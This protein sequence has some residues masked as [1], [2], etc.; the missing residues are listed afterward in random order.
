METLGVDIWQYILELL[1][2]YSDQASL[3][4]TCRFTWYK[5]GIKKICFGKMTDDILK[6]HIFRELTFLEIY[7]NHNITYLG[8][9]KLKSLR[10]DCAYG[11]TQESIANLT[12]LTDLHIEG[13]STIVDLN[14][15]TNLK[16]LFID[17]KCGL[18]QIGIQKLNLTELEIWDDFTKFDVSHMT[19]LKKLT[20]WSRSD[21]NI[22]QT[23]FAN[24]NLVK[25]EACDPTVEW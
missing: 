5:L 18:T 21:S 11:I 20:V 7:D 19:N 23:Y 24:L 3:V 15:M 6:Y 4:S 9:L 16:K 17:H 25:L 8:H 22:D 13:N 2:D 10:I 14:H 12:N 1:D